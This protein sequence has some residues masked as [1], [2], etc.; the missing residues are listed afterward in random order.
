MN[1]PVSALYFPGPNVCDA[2]YLYLGLKNGDVRVID[3]KTIEQTNFNFKY[4][5]LTNEMSQND[6]VI[7]LSI[8]SQSLLVVYENFGFVVFD[9]KKQKVQ[10]KCKQILIQ[11]IHC[12][13]FQS[14]QKFT[15]IVFGHRDGALRL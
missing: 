7:G 4:G 5:E 8:C 14:D 2:S 10:H 12:F 15:S 13:A 11:Q 3:L 9:I 6:Q 1:Y